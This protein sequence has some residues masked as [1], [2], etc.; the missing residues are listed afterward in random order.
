MLRKVFLGV[1]FAGLAGCTLAQTQSRPDT[2]FSAPAE[3]SAPRVKTDN[4]PRIAV[5]TAF[6]P[7]LAAL[8]PR[9]S[10]QTRHQVNGVSFWTGTIS[11]QEVVLFM[12]GVSL[13]NAAMNT[14]LVLERFNVTNI[15]VSGIAGGVDPELSIG[16]VTVPAKWGQYNETVYMRE[17][18]PGVF[19]PHAETKP[20]IAEFGFIRPRGVWV[21][22]ADNTEPEPRFWFEADDQLL[23]IAHSASRAIAL[24]QCISETECLDERPQVVLGGAGV[25]GSIFLDNAEF[26][27]YLFDTFDAQVA[28]ME[29]SS[30]AMVAYAN[31]IPYIAFRSLSDLAGGGGAGENEMKVFGTLAAENA[32]AFVVAFL[33]AYGQSLPAA[34][35]APTPDAPFCELNYATM[36]GYS[37]DRLGAAR[38]EKLRALTEREEDYRAFVSSFDDLTRR[39]A[40]AVSPELTLTSFDVLGGYKGTTGPSL[41]GVIATP[42]EADRTAATLIGAALGYVYLQESVIVQCDG[43][44]AGAASMPSFDLVETGPLDTLNTESIKSIYGMMIGEANGELTLGFTYYPADDRFSSL[45]FSDAGAVESQLLDTIEMRLDG[46]TGLPDN[47]ERVDTTRWVR[48]VGHDWTADTSGNSYFDGLLPAELKP[49][50][51]QLQTE[52]IAAIDAL[53]QPD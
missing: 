24:K 8:L 32:A 48:F 44:H 29:T 20:P 9:L 12:T 3:A 1:V 34:D 21:A 26:R 42:T 37:G 7:E 49:Q 18:E 52:Y 30:I 15:V 41:S 22:A 50:L 19:E 40:A 27:E 33:D 14:Q 25:S 31:D 17:I 5:A 38:L 11:D 35:I 2:T 43:P 39:I 47:T 45:G 46:W 23:K 51:D 6:A 13:V 4:V 53:P 16:D 10:N 36:A 28:E